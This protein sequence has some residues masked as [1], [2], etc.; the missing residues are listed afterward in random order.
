MKNVY[1][2]EKAVKA[3]IILVANRER[4]ALNF[5]ML[6]LGMVLMAFG[7]EVLNN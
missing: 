4:S 5:R 1:F 3:T 7:G 2:G 6:D